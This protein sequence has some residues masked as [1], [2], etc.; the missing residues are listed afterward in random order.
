MSNTIPDDIW[1]EFFREGLGTL[2]GA[3]MA[4]E[5][6]RLRALRVS[7]TPQ[8]VASSTYGDLPTILRTHILAHEWDNMTASEQ[9][10]WSL[11]RL[12]KCERILSVEGANEIARTT[13]EE[14]ARYWRRNYQNDCVISN[15]GWHCER[16][17]RQVSGIVN[18]VIAD[19]RRNV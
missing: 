10:D 11:D 12:A 2:D 15:S 14:F 5:I 8:P 4:A 19:E 13:S 18:R 3:A 1:Q 9:R 16:I 6:V 7:I 17:A